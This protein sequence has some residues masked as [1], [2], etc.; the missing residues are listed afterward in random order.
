MA[1]AA[2]DGGGGGDKLILRGLQFHGFHG[3][4]REERTLGQKFVVDVD[5]W[6]DLAAAG[7]SDSIAHTVSYTDIYRLVSDSKICS[8]FF[9]IHFFCSAL[10]CLEQVDMVTEVVF[11][12]QYVRMQFQ[13]NYSFLG[14]VCFWL[15]HSLQD[16]EECR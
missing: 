14:T 6:M 7:E 13:I 9:T 16:S 8:E 4:K 3:V 1:E 2:G 15:D 12:I 5:A 11:Q 10:L